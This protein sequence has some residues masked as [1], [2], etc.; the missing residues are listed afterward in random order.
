VISWTAQPLPSADAL[1]I[2]LDVER[3]RP[4]TL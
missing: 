4:A 2:Q 3:I 1:E